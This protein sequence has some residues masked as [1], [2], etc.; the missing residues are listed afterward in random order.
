MCS[1]YTCHTHLHLIY[2]NSDPVHCTEGECKFTILWNIETVWKFEKNSRPVWDFHF[3][4]SSVQY[5]EDCFHIHF[6]IG[7][8]HIWF[9][10]MTC[11]HTPLHGFIWNQHNDQLSVGLLA[12]LVEHCTGIA[13]VMGSNPVRAWIFF[14]PYFHYC[15]SSAHYCEDHFHSNNYMV[16]RL[17]FFFILTIVATLIHN[18]SLTVMYILLFLR[19]WSE[20]YDVMI[21]FV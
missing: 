15:S 7:N 21:L 3:I 13:K 18:S 17:F 4:S 2:L 1:A 11:I 9:S 5:W 12:Q 14:R 8:S 6:F 19:T 10:F 16:S 20:Y